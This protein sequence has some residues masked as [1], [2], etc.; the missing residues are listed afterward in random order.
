MSS[1]PVSMKRIPSRTTEKKWQRRFSNYNTICCHGNQWS[2]LAEFRTHPS[3]HVRGCDQEQTRKSGDIVLP[4][5][6]LW[7][8]FRR[9]RAADS[10]VDGPI[11]PKFEI[12]RAL[13]H[14]I[15]TCKYE[16]KRMK[17]NREK[18]ETLFFSH[19][20]PICYHGN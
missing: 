13:K 8:F 18:V 17:N 10:A 3:S 9:S 7:E 1:L 16:K 20:N 19:H 15:V 6:S 4:A 14:V 2:D 5:I 12:V 11:R